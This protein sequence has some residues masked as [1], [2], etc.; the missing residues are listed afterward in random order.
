MRDYLTLG[1]MYPDLYGISAILPQ[2]SLHDSPL[3]NSKSA[4]A[5]H[6]HGDSPRIKRYKSPLPFLIEVVE[7]RRLFSH[8][9]RT[10]ATEP[11]LVHRGV[12]R[13]LL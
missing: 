6:I 5:P 13:R 7:S 3:L 1:R 12:D 10:P 4:T 2:D 11:S 9:D 8:D